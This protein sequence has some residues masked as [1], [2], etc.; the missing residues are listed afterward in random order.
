VLTRG[1]VQLLSGVPV[2]AA[3]GGAVTVMAPVNV[4]STKHPQLFFNTI[5]GEYTPL[6]PYVLHG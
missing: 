1:D 3:K 4:V 5:L 6:A 2:N